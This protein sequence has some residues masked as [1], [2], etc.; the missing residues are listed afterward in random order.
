MEVDFIIKMGFFVRNLYNHITALHA[1]QYGGQ[2][3]SDSFTVYRG[4]G[5]SQ[6]DFGQLKQT[7]GGLLAF[8]N[9]LF[10]SAN[11]DVS[12]EFARRTM[13]TSKLVG[14]LFIL[15]I[16]PSI[17]TTPFANVGKVT[18]YQGEEKEILFSMHSIFRIGQVKQIDESDRLW[19]VDLTLTGDND[20]QLQALTERIREETQGSTGWDQLGKLMTK[21]GQFDRAEELYEILLQQTSNEDEEGHLYHM[22]GMVKSDQGKYVEAASFYEKFI[23]I[24]QKIL[25][26]THAE[27]TAT[28]NSIGLVYK[29]MGEYSKALS[30]CEKA[31]EILQKTLPVDHPSLAATYNSIGAVYYNMGEYS[32]AFSYYEKALEIKRKTL[33][34][35][36]PDFAQ[37]YNNIGVVYYNMGEY[38]KALSYYGKALEIRPKT[39]P[40]NHP[41]LAASYNNIG[42]LYK[43]MGEYSKALLYYRK[44]LDIRKK[45][46]PTNHPSFATSYNNIGSLYYNMGDYQKALSYSE[47]ALKIWQRSLP[48]KHPSIKNVKESIEIVKMKL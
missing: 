48:A 47:R 4:Q 35:N 28:Y 37:S 33:P 30:Y 42:A 31:L 15:K 6:T 1:E 25:P 19:Q 24:N 9:F 16:D 32:E 26:P 14:I 5:L 23:K 10:T 7:Q 22:L 43:N 38:S 17:A 11:S 36:H 3:H 44:A 39:L 21:L 27:L 2:H 18:Y 13:A 41:S 45:S 46:L 40:A 12:L 29:N 34:A 8:N 20:P